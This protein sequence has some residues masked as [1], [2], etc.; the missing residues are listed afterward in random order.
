MHNIVWYVSKKSSPDV[1]IDS[2]TLRWCWHIPT[3]ITYIEIEMQT[4]NGYIPTSANA[5]L[6]M[7]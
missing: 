3:C 1:R 6:R 7:I 4:S 2:M 5:T